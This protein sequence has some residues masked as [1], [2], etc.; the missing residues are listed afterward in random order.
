MRLVW[1]GVLSLLLG[2]ALT[3]AAKPLEDGFKQPPD[4]ARPW[5]FWFWLNGNTTSNGI[6][7][8]LEAMRRAGIG[9]V[10]V[11]EVDQGTPA[12]PVAFGSQS[13]RQ[14][15][16]HV[17]T[18]AKRLGLQV[19]MNND[20][21]W[22]GSGGPW[23][24]PEL[25]MQKVV[26]S[27]T[28][29]QGP[30]RY[31]GVLKHPETVSN[32]YRDIRVMAFP[33]GSAEE[34]SMQQA[35][36]V[37]T[38][39]GSAAEGAARP[40][41][42]FELPHPQLDSP[43]FLQ[44]AFPKPYTARRLELLTEGFS[45][46]RTGH[47]QIQASGDGVSYKTLREFD[48]ADS[49]LEVSFPEVTT[50]FYRVVFL[51]ADYKVKQIVV[52]GLDLSSRLRLDNAGVKTLAVPKKETP[53]QARFAE[54]A[55]GTAIPRDQIVDLSSRMAVDGRLSW[56]V[57]PGRWAVLR[58]GHASNGQD[59]HPAPA[60]GR[61]LECDK[62]SK[63]G[64]EAMFN[65][66]VGRLA[67]ENSGLTGKVFCGTHIDSWE[68]GPQNWT[69]N[70][71]AEFLRLRGYDPLPLLPVL[72]GR[73]VQSVEVSERF[74]WD[75]RRTVGDLLVE[76]YAGHL[77]KLARARRLQL[78][79]E[80]YDGVPCDDLTYAGR[81][82]VPM[83]EFWSWVPY[84]LAF[85]CTEMASAA[86]VYGKPIVAA[87][88]FT[89][90]E[91]EKWL[92]HPYAVKAYGDWAFCEGINRFVIHR[93]AFQP[94]S[95]PDHAPGLAMG[96]FGL[97]YERTQTWWEYSR[98]WHDYL[99]RCQYLLQ[100]GQFVADICY[101]APE[102]SPQRWQPPVPALERPGYNF[103][104]CPPEVLLNRMSVKGGRLVLPDGMSYRVLVLPACDT[105]TPQLLSRIRDLVV[106]GAT[107]IGSRPLKSPSLEGYPQCDAELCAL[108]DEMWGDADGVKVKEHRLGR[109][110]VLCGVSPDDLLASMGVAYDF[111][112]APMNS[113][114][115]L[116]YIHKRLG[117]AEVYFVASRLNRSED[118]VCLF[119]V[120]DKHP[121]LWHPDTGKVEPVAVYETVNGC[122]R[123]P[124][125]L[126]PCGSV[127]VVFRPERRAAVDP[128][129]SVTR[130]SQPVLQAAAPEASVRA[131]ESS[132]DLAGTFTLCGWV[133]PGTE[134][135]LPTESG[136]G[137]G[138]LLCRRNDALYPP[139]GQEVYPESNQAGVGVSAGRNGACVFEHG[140]GLFAPVL[141]QEAA[142]SDWTHVA[143][144]YSKGVPSLYLNGRW[145]HSGRKS[146]FNPHAGVG[147]QHWRNP[148]PFDGEL[149]EFQKYDRVLTEAEI[150]GLSRRTPQPEADNCRPEL[151]LGP[152]S[153]IQ[154]RVWQTGRYEARTRSG[155]TLS[156]EVADVPS[157]L[158][159]EGSWELGFP[160]GWGAPEKVELPKLISW[161][162]HEDAGVRYFSG[163]G[164]YLKTFDL[165]PEVLKPGQGLILDLGRVSVMAAV[166]LN[167][168]D[169]GIL[170][171]PPFQVD[172]TEAA[173][174]GANRLE[175]RVVNL[176]INRLIGDEQLAEDSERDSKGTLL[177]WPEWL[178]KPSPA[179]RFAFTTWR[180]WKKGAPL[181][182]SGLLGPVRV[183]FA[184]DVVLEK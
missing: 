118:A 81:A 36:A 95:N 169:L 4:S 99:A 55:P 44:V 42:R 184:R 110:R 87:E 41:G 39:G 19:S 43:Q 109:G 69:A 62:L 64:V 17:C 54:P 138:G 121:E 146:G 170:W 168:K 8:D 120:K 10:V 129:V 75:F 91:G 155:K 82:D 27:E 26:W 34:N 6:T 182:E 77:Q 45:R 126:D 16:R 5:V 165:G 103:D 70:F 154:A 122:T 102:K 111:E 173:K 18:E 92:G 1:L 166:R 101:L 98:P 53:N 13:W 141:V 88:A 32:Y 94:W 181:Q 171:K 136:S 130:D 159:V 143:V 112:A 179:G 114:Q 71:S 61:G 49:R 74:L 9:G 134:I 25:S 178:G 47:G 23:I 142:L 150:L 65:A 11:M 123:L 144:V 124:L 151:V 176:W 22:C 28:V 2:G 3:L 127:F 35:G 164:T 125:H 14:L 167:G 139:P 148:A 177:S 158:S 52:T 100:Q 135:E 30:G 97:H 183:R 67:G 116:R 80:A 180:Q 153:A 56:D 46:L 60:S 66:L 84:G 113:Q 119:R 175:V 132:S 106:D 29:V 21:G 163:T 117:D 128:V 33:V 24:T 108:A 83:G 93:Y 78:S 90:A 50:R 40:A 96:P 59:N 68:V 161:S 140:S 20:A 73:V 174:P 79:I 156:F 31:E 72:T 115:R 172:I 76:N 160:A 131:L 145:T 51:N 152:K 147:V 107:V 157:P 89:A 137:S 58:F 38:V 7:A 57:P 162:R 86:H 12:G 48:V 149:G 37:V 85:S 133:K 105:M 15:F 63:A 104:G